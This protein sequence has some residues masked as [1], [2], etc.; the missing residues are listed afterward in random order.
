MPRRYL[1]RILCL[2]VVILPAC[3]KVNKDEGS[4][5]TTPSIAPASDD[6]R[7][8]KA[9]HQKYLK[10]HDE[11]TV[12][13]VDAILKGYSS[14]TTQQTKIKASQGGSASATKLSRPCRYCKEFLDPSYDG[15]SAYIFF[16]EN[17]RVVGKSFVEWLG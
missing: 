16:D 14:K 3:T 8:G 17:D 10:V 4:P 1:L 9:F 6:H 12:L 5:T 13:E 2:G 7:P 15:Y 11:L